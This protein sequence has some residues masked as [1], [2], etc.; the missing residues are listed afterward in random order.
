MG[1]VAT[2]FSWL[3]QTDQGVEVRAVNVY[4]STCVMNLFANFDNVGVID[5]GGRWVGDHDRGDAISVFL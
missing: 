4:L 3:G 5:T 1:H 2:K